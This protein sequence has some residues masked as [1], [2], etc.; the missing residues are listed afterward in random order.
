MDKLGRRSVLRGA[1]GGAAVTVGL[2]ILDR[3]LNGN[4]TAF[5]KTGAA[6][7]VCFGHYYQGLGLNPGLWIPEKIGANYENNVQLKVFDRFRDRMNLFSG[8]RYFLDGRPHET[9]TSTVQIASTG[10]V[11]DSGRIGP[12]LDS[13]IADVIG[14]KTRF[15]SIEVSPQGSRQ[16]WSRRS[17]T[18]INP[19]EPSP[20]SLYMR[21]FGPEFKDPN[22]AEFTPDPMVMARRSVLSAVTEQRQDVMR[23]LDAADRIRL[24]EFFTS[25]REIEQ[26]LDLELQQPAPLEACDI[27]VRP[28]EEKPSSVIDSVMHNGKIFAHLLAYAMACGQTRV[29]NVA[30]S[31][32]WREAG[33]TYNWHTATHEEAVDESLG[34][35]KKV[36]WFISKSNELFAEFLSVLDSVREGPGTLLDRTLVV[37]QSDHGDARTHS[38]ENVPVMTAGGGAGLIKTGIHVAAPGDP[39]T[40]VGLTVQQALGVPISAWGDR[41]NETSRTITDIL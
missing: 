28:E 19:S 26:R 21:V 18:S 31:G 27:P 35:Q 37:W 34:Y 33:E 7:P 38:I 36:Y 11:F 3:F 22:A 10:A 15:R 29:F 32:F 1:V 40:R 8:M 4:G 30:N 20:A 17:A 23:Q 13:N 5:A 24:D 6:L 39:C 2:P 41:S 12:S 14:N 25:I 9:H 16:S